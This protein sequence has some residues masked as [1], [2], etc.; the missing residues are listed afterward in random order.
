MHGTLPS[1]RISLAAFRA[2]AACLIGTVSGLFLAVAAAEEGDA[3]RER[4]QKILEPLQALV[5]KWKGTG[6]PKRG[7]TAGGWTEQ[8]E[9]AWKFS[10]E[11]AAIQFQAVDAKYFVGG[12]F[13]PGKEAG[14][15]E[16]V[17][18]RAD[19]KAEL[20]YSGKADGADSWILTTAEPPKGWPARI[21]LR[22]VAEGKRLVALYEQRLGE[23]RYLRLAEVGY[24]REG[25]GFG[26]GA[27][28]PECVVTGGF[29]DREVEYKGK[30]YKVCCEGC[31]DLFLMDP[32]KVLAEYAA[33][34]A[35]RKKPK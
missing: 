10:K 20:V 1:T 24:T 18:T 15:V 6:L 22:L 3:A 9:W 21:T 26:S 28:Y 11:H 32:E 7:S 4:D 29:A 16:L 17:L 8:S 35:E 33:R 19:T 5:G 13:R 34:Q 14:Q 12:A 30:K 2:F 27:T 31:R 25:S 23:D